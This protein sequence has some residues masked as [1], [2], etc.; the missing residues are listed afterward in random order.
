MRVLS[1]RRRLRVDRRGPTG[2]WLH[3]YDETVHLGP[4]EPNGPYAMYLA[5]T[6]G[7]YRLLAFDLDAARGDV[8]ADL[9]QLQGILDRAGVR[10]AVVASGPSASRHVWVHIPEG[11]NARLVDQL[12]RAAKSLLPTLDLAPLTNAVAGCVRPPG[13]PHRHGGRA[14]IIGDV[15]VAIHALT[16][17]VGTDAIERV[18]WLLGLDTAEATTKPTTAIAAGAAERA[19]RVV[20]DPDGHRRITGKRRPVSA[21]VRTWISEPMRSDED[22]NRRLWRILCSLARRRW[23]Y[24]DVEQLAG[25]GGPGWTHVQSAAATNGARTHYTADESRRTLGRQW[26]RA[27]SAV[28]QLME[29][30]PA[31]RIHDAD[32][33]D[34]GE[35]EAQLCAA[36]QLVQ[37]RANDEPERW[38]RPGGPSDRR[39]LDHLCDLILAAL[40][41]EIEADLRRLAIACGLSRECIRR[42]LARLVADRWIALA[43][44]GSGRRGDVWQL[45]PTEANEEKKNPELSQGAPRPLSRGALAEILLLRTVLA[46]H[47]VFT[48]GNGGLGHHVARTYVALVELQDEPPADSQGR[49]QPVDE[50]ALARSTGYRRTTVLRHLRRLECYQMVERHPT[51]WTIGRVSLTDAAYV[52]GSYGVAAARALRYAIERQVWEWWQV[53]VA[54][55]RTRR[56]ERAERAKQ[57]AVRRRNTRHGGPGQLALA[58]PGLDP[59]LRWPKFPRIGRRR[60]P[61]HTRAAELVRSGHALDG[62]PIA[63]A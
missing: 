35:R 49:T 21:Q 31:H 34:A 5:T 1:P 22:M 30:A 20:I 43:A 9:A 62:E 38:A 48:H 47:D 37:Q 8:H 25:A 32:D 59:S 7:Q 56:A 44:S 63:A 28:D 16:V 14:E 55:I 17:G 12:A 60:R 50:Q 42:A 23:S 29:A 46:A 18:A 45:V 11:L 39:V 10:Y 54:R 53:E 13:A 36:V 57:G 3:S 58:T 61:D 33:T 26:D 52:T 27:V 2:E 40:S 24:A 19:S 4:Q 6:A 51:G 15:D 41:L